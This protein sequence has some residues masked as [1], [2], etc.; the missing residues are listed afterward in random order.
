MTEKNAC[1]CCGRCSEKYGAGDGIR[2]DLDAW[3]QFGRAMGKH[4][5][6]RFYVVALDVRNRPIGKRMV[7]HGSMT[8][9]PV[10][11]REVFSY[12]IKRGAVQA[13]LVHNHPSGDV[14]PSD[15]DLAITKRL[16]AVGRLVDIPVLDHLIVSRHGFVGLRATHP[17]I[18]SKEG[19]GVG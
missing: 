2:S 13:I 18:W 19:G 4:R 3:E 6:E 14:K 12:L 1:P 17:E 10:H 8:I 11:P 15:D 7:A 5:A 9:C 16:I